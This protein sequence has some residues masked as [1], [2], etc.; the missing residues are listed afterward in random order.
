MLEMTYDL[1]EVN[2]LFG[3]F[4]DAVR[5]ATVSKVT[6]VLMYLERLVKQAT[7]QGAGPAHLMQTIGPPEVTVLG[8]KVKGMLG[9]PAKYA[10]PVEYGTRPHFPPIEPIKYWVEKKLG[11]E[12][13]E[14]ASVAFLIA[15]KISKEGTE[16]AYMFTDTWNEHQDDINRIL[17]Q[18]PEN[19]LE[20][21]Q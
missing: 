15:R 14:A 11:L 18:I 10:E 20:R 21:L 9:T 19:I 1:S 6:E 4:P 13:A 5:S 8:D 3:E 7:P 16:G 17:D 2:K 12:G